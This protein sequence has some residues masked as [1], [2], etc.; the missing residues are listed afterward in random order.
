MC[1]PAGIRDL[2]RLGAVADRDRRLRHQ[3]APGAVD[4]PPDPQHHHRRA[5][6]LRGPVLLSRRDLPGHADGAGVQPRSCAKPAGQV[7]DRAAVRAAVRHRA[8]PG[9]AV[10]TPRV[11]GR[12]GRGPHHRGRGLAHSGGQQHDRSVLGL[13]ERGA[14]GTASGPGAGELQR[15]V[16][17]G[18]L[19]CRAR[20]REAGAATRARRS[21]GRSRLSAARGRDKL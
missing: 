4:R 14:A 9:A 3:R 6:A 12:G 8:T 1:G 10:A 19:R 13:R 2:P 15:D 21:P 17:A 16:S 11:R 20:V 7:P 18:S 5:G